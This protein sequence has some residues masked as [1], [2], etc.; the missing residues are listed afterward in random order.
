[1]LVVY[2]IDKIWCS[3]AGLEN[4]AIPF[5]DVQ[6]S[7][8]KEHNWNFTTTKQVGLANRSIN[9]PRGKILGGSTSIS[10]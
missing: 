2:S 8:N 1:M 10:E 6:L 4:F 7:P 3:S 9:Y 5:F